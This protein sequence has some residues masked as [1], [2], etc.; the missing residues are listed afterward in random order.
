L[1]VLTVEHDTAV[2]AEQLVVM[3][4][5]FIACQLLFAVRT[6][7]VLRMIPLAF[8]GHAF[9]NDRSLA[10]GANESLLVVVVLF[11]V[12]GT[13]MLEERAIEGRLARLADEAS[14]MPLFAESVG[15]FSL[16]GF[17]TTSALGC[18]F[19]EVIG[20]TIGLAVAAFHERHIVLQKV[21]LTNATGQV[22]F[23]PLHAKCGELILRDCLAACRTIRSDATASSYTQIESTKRIQLRHS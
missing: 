11:A 3:I 8:G 15:G 21:P 23:V 16:N 4:E 10:F 2:F 9:T 22:L 13:F 5:V 18:E 14:W 12:R 7:E 20:L 19:S 1:F 17:G 6:E